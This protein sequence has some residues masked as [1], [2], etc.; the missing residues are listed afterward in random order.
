MMSTS[1]PPPRRRRRG[2]AAAAVVVVEVVEN[3][4]PRRPNVPSET[5]APRAVFHPDALVGE[6][7][8]YLLH[9]TYDLGVYPRVPPFHEDDDEQHRPEQQQHRREEAD[10]PYPHRP[11]EIRVEVIQLRHDHVIQ[12][13]IPLPQ[14]V[15]EVIVVYLVVFVCAPP[16]LPFPPEACIDL[17][18]YPG[19]MA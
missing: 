2:T 7:Q 6:T 16:P 8:P 19:R 17:R 11:V 14:I 12:R 4:H 5:G 10:A 1:T 3:H 15:L 13:V 9:R 18:S